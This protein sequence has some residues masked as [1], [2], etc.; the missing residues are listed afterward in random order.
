MPNRF[1]FSRPILVCSAA[2]LAALTGC[3]RHNDTGAAARAPAYSAIER[4]AFNRRA[5]ELFLPLFW[6][7]DVNGNGALDPDELA[8]L[9]GYP[10]DTWTSW[11]DT[12]GRF[13]AEF[14]RAYEQM[15][16]ADAVP[17]DAAEQ[18]RQKLVREEL[19]QGQPTLVAND[20]S[21]A[22]AAEKNFLD[23]MLK[24]GELVERIYARQ[25]GVFGL[26][27]QIPETDRASL[28]MFH[29]N[30][31]PFCE[32]PKTESDPGCSAIAPKPARI[33][34]LYPADIQ[35]DPGFC[36]VLEK[37]PNA[38]ALMDHFSVVVAGDKPGTY[39]AVP[40]N[41]AYRLE[42]EAIA[43]ELKAAASG[44]GDDEAALKHY[45]LAAAQSFRSNDWEPANA[46]WVA[47]GAENSKWFVRIAPDEVY[48]EPCAWKAGFALQVARINPESLEWQRKLD[49]MKNDMENA[50]AAMA[51]KPYKA[52]DVKF[53]I[54]D[55]ID[56]VIN[57]GDQRSATGATI[58]Q[59]LPNW[60]PTAEKGGRT[61]AMTNLY[62][63]AD[64]QATQT[65]LMSSVFCKAT[66]ATANTSPREQLIGSLLHEAAHNLGPSHEYKVNGKEDDAL[67][68]GT[69]A[70]TLEELKAQTSSLYLTDWLAA[71]GVFTA[72]EVR[73]IQLR[74]IAWAFG[75]ISR[76]MYT[77]D[78][79]P[80]N[81]SQLAAMQVGAFMK[82]GAL[83]WKPDEP[84]ANGT[85]QG[86]M[87]INFETLPAAI[88]SFETTVL[89]IKGS[90]DKAG[91]EKL[92]ADFVDAKDGFAD[93][94]G[95]IAERW[96]R[97]PKASFVYSVKH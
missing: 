6:R 91:A 85:D 97:S 2:L 20:F 60:G 95:V 21:Q 79:T 40:Y 78:G 86:C 7:E 39:R 26:E 73:R 32:A 44:F 8:V 42:M 12:S 5:A 1:S 61:V 48:Y 81:Y 46:A 15:Q 77:A 82:S 75:H 28:A 38:A 3:S 45:L 83:V 90:G 50:L 62:T 9:T 10:Q 54:P 59:S 68:G 35:S 63:D 74:N 66:N 96:L 19:A 30:Q 55:F 4:V 84:A 41:E 16:K 67:F 31:S 22:A 43:T 89:K 23:H 76:G 34:G 80:R 72:D 24:V 17:A 71:K 57:A 65:R 37:Q 51:G 88:E 56:V 18:T 92:K 25:K 52:R 11:I 87:E 14:S 13:T 47:M 64:S 93:L 29:R 53:K 33:V 69:M 27:A 58:G 36:A 49:P 70:S 94:K